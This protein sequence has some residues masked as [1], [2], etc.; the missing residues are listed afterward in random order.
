MDLVDGIWLVK[1]GNLLIVKN[2]D[3]EWPFPACPQMDSGGPV[4][5]PSEGNLNLGIKWLVRTEFIYVDGGNMQFEA[6]KNQAWFDLDKLTQPLTLRIRRDGDRF[7]PLGMEGRQMKVSDCMINE[8]LPARA[9]KNYPLVCSGDNIIWIPG[10][11]AGHTARVSPET[12]RIL[13][14]TLVRQD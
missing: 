14:I 13:H 3:D 11:K 8:H 5:L 9:R 10:V 12:R 4:D 7:E 6:G 1:L 2:K